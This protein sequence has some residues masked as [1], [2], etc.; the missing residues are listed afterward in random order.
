MTQIDLQMALSAHR[1]SEDLILATYADL[2]MD[3]GCG[4]S[5]ADM[6]RIQQIAYRIMAERETTFGSLAIMAVREAMEKVKAGM[7]VTTRARA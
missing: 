1:A 5:Q 4:C 3:G 7:R 6:M 2:L